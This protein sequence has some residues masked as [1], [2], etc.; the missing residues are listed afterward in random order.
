MVARPQMVERWTVSDGKLLY[1]FTLRPGLKFSDGSPVTMFLDG[2]TT[3]IA[4]ERT[5]ALLWA[6]ARPH[7]RR[8]DHV[9]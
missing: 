7:L 6:G 2:G 9:G 1:T 3:V 8:Y 4:A 5:P